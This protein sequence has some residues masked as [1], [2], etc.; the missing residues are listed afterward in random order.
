MPADD[1]DD[2]PPAWP[3][4]LPSTLAACAVAVLNTAE[5]AAKISMTRAA[6][7]ALRAGRLP[8]GVGVAAPPDEPARPARP[9]L[10]PLRAASD[11]S[12]A[13][14]ALPLP[15]AIL[16]SLAHVE[17]SAVSLAWDTVARFSPL[18][19]RGSLPPL[20]FHDFARVADDEARHLGWC[21][22]RL[23]ALG[24]DYGDAVAH[25]ELWRAAAATA[26]C[27]L[28][29]LAVVPC[30]QEA[31]GLD[32]GARLAAKLRG[33]GDGAGARLVERI[34]GEEGPHVCVGAAWLTQVARARGAEPA[35]AFAAAVARHVPGGLKG[36]F[37]GAA[38]D[39]AGLP[40]GWWQPPAGAGAVGAGAG[41][42]QL[43]ARLGDM[44]AVDRMLA[45]A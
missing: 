6:F 20:F 18:G 34:A 35:G 40:R 3:G 16:H 1:E 33:A 12:H 8:G 27:A 28:D 5:P 4:P 26:G 41:R 17:H 2:A 32:A 25:D 19:A 29:R 22:A 37:N 11:A 42:G 31:R 7:A 44:V 39:A 15:A 24:C 43:A 14:G 30:V 21:L 13:A 23:R 36:P 45:A 38:R 9:V 10:V